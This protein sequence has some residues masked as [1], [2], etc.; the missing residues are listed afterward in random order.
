MH[1]AQVAARTML[2]HDAR[3]WPHADFIKAN[4]L[5]LEARYGDPAVALRML[6]TPGEAPMMTD[7][8]LADWR[9]FASA[10]QS[11]DKAKIAAYVNQVFA[12]VASKQLNVGQALVR[13]ISLGGPDAVF[14]MT[15]QASPDD[16]VETE[17]LFRS[18]AA[19]VRADPRFLPLM[20]K[21]GVLAFWRATNHWADFCNAQDR[22]Y[23]CR[24]EAAKLGL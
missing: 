23:D 9:A 14:R 19:A 13:L 21:T 7:A 16:P 3:V 17:P 4:R 12:N 6:S 20:A 11:G 24:S 15:A 2:E 10:R 5:G 22:P 1:G 8:Q 18:P